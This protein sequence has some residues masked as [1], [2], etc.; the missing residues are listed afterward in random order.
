MQCPCCGKT[1]QEVRTSGL[2][3]DVCG[4]CGGS[5]F[6]RGEFKETLDRMLTAGDVPHATVEL[7]GRPASVGTVREGSR[8]CPRCGEPMAKLNYC[9]DSN[10]ILDRC[11]HCQGIW[12]DRSEAV[13]CAQYRKGNPKLDRLGTSVAKNVR[14]RQAF[15]E[16]CAEADSMVLY[17]RCWGWGAFSLVPLR[18]DQP[19]ERLPVVTLALIGLNV[20]VF[21]ILL[22]TLG[23][24]GTAVLW[25]EGGSEVVRSPIQRVFET[26][27]T[28]PARLVKGRQ[29]WGLLTGM[30]L[31]V[32][33]MHL[34]GNMLFLYI[35][36]DNV[37]DRFGR[38]RFVGFYLLCGLAADLAHT[39]ANPGSTVPAVG[40]SGAISGVMGAYLVFFPQASIYTLIW[41]QLRAI[42][43]W[44]YLGIWI[45]LQIACALLY[46]GTGG[47]AGVAW[48][49]HIGGFASG[50]VIA[51]VWK[52]RRVLAPAV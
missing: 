14:K 18:D 28:V 45:A 37:E 13:K 7:R 36:G 32:G 22:V 25:G 43:A 15:E 3:I 33:V 47:G 9:Y 48:L 21:L 40:A 50:V 42:P 46:A 26:F 2:V 24:N 5:F 16:A 44:V 19:S 35:F 23:H 39:L 41:Y 4:G 20:L 11:P 30:F 38:W 1:L 8:S 12:A 31:H 34:I 49:A 51:L 6:D 52:R 27:G 17:A 29:L 10:I